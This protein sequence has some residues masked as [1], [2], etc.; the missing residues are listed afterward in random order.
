[1]IGNRITKP[2]TPRRARS[3]ARLT[4]PALALLLAV[5][6]AAAPAQAVTSEGG[7]AALHSKTRLN[8]PV[9]AAAATWSKL[10][11]RK[12]GLN[13][14][15]VRLTASLPALRA[16]A[17]TRGS[18]LTQARRTRTAATTALARATT[19]DRAAH[20]G[21]ATAKTAAAAAK[22][23]VIAAEKRKPRDNY[24]ITRARK[25]LAAANATGK[26]RAATAG[27]TTAALTTARTALTTATHR[28][29]TATTADQAATKVITDT[30]QKIASLPPLASALARQAAAVSKDA[31]TQTRA[32][33]TPAQT[34]QVY[35]VTVNRIVAYPF[36]R[37]VDDAARAGIQLSGGGFRTRQQQ[38]AL[39]TVNGCPDIWTAPSSSCRV[40]TAIPGRSLH[41]LGLAIDMTSGS[42]TINDRKSPAFKW[43]AAYA[44]RYG[45]VNLPSEPWHWSITGN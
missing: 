1:V 24:R 22:K 41:E 31:V 33:F 42:R 27:R 39:R 3:A 21:Y 11:Q 8:A 35:G 15:S 40:P 34:T 43:L 17:A 18:E 6:T 7:Y 19:A 20:A 28:V 32:T 2:T 16:T 5:T 10:M 37:M 45:F 44:A 23:A 30:R 12:L 25:A 9:A 29:A 14:Q 36:Q 13:T 4:V 38:I 26:A